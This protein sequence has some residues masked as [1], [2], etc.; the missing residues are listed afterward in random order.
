M[1][2]NQ[3]LAEAGIEVIKNERLDLQRGAVVEEGKIL[4]VTM[5]ESETEL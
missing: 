2:Y 4:S 5:R 1:I 3:M